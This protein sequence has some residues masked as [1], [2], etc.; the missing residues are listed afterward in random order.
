MSSTSSVSRGKLKSRTKNW[1]LFPPLNTMY[2]TMSKTNHMKT[3][4][5]HKPNF[6]YPIRVII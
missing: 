1:Q 5:P 4:N 2:K 6:N 3:K